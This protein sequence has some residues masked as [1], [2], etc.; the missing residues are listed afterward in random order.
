MHR[1]RTATSPDKGRAGG[2]ALGD[3]VGEIL[4]RHLE[5]GISAVARQFKSTP[6]FLPPARIIR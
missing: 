4:R 1:R 3:T 2:N 5:Y 6:L